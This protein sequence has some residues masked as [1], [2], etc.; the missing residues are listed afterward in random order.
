MTPRT[1]I[2]LGVAALSVALVWGL[3]GAA[4]KPHNTS[5]AG[6][7]GP[8]VDD[9]K[10][11]LEEKRFQ[12]ATAGLDFTGSAVR[13]T[14]PVRHDRT[15][16][17]AAY[18]AGERILATENVWFTAVGNF[19][20]AVVADPS[21]APAFEAMSRAFLLE[22]DVE[23][24]EKALKAALIADPHFDK[25]QFS[26]G[27][28]RQANGD[29]EGALEQWN[30]LALRNPAY[31]DTYARMSIASY[32]KHDYSSAWKYLDEAQRRKQNVPPQFIPLLKEAA[33]RP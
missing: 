32:Y 31:P 7:L 2:G 24:S 16:A 22:G 5:R 12:D 27:L 21:Y 25:A 26:L 19:R 3:Q 18:K 8:V 14:A 17:L 30:A 6:S 33:P 11:A 23:H 9:P 4:G 15:K 1:F 29:Y 28:S 20:D 13:V 10:E